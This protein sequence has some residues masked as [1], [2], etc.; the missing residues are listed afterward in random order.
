MCGR[1]VNNFNITLNLARFRA[2]LRSAMS[3]MLRD[4][5][6][7]PNYNVAPTHQVQ[8]VFQA[9]KRYLE[10]AQWGWKAPWKPGTLLVNAKAETAPD[11]RT[12]AVQFR[13]QRCLM[14]A[15]AFY[16]WKTD[17][18]TGKKV[19]WLFRLKS[20]EPFAF[21]ALWDDQ[22]EQEQWHRRV[23]LLTTLPNELVSRV[24]NRMPVMLNGA[25]EDAWL[26]PD[27]SV[28]QLLS[29][30]APYPLAEME[31]FPVSPLV[32]NVRNNSPDLIVPL[33]G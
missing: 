8:M 23:L 11:K 28:D 18:A 7:V 30:C 9:E 5:K 29:S 16:E 10:F 33:A 15:S 14:L 13:E 27:A 26:D 2:S 4:L 6:D 3:D 1:F 17:E 20:G 21:A 32:N 19:P 24:H 22:L 12:F 25:D 31:G